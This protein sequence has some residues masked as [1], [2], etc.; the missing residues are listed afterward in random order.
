[1]VFAKA[2]ELRRHQPEAAYQRLSEWLVTTANA[3]YLMAFQN[4]E[5]GVLENPMD[6]AGFVARLYWCIHRQ[7]TTY[8]VE[9]WRVWLGQASD[10]QKYLKRWANSEW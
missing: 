7:S 3:I 2:R 4:P 10:R 8:S 1:M 6:Q 5:L 9:E